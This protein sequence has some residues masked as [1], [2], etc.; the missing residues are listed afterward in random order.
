MIGKLEFIGYVIAVL[1]SGSFL[2]GRLLIRRK[3]KRIVGEYGSVRKDYGEL[4]TTDRHTAITQGYIL[5]LLWPITFAVWFVVFSTRQLA[6]NVFVPMVHHFELKAEQRRRLERGG[7]GKLE[8]L[9]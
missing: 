4:R 6:N 5:G 8:E 2:S 7:L 9:P 1:T 3:Y